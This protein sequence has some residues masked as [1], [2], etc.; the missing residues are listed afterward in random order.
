MIAARTVPL[1]LCALLAHASPLR[2]QDDAG[3]ELFDAEL[4]AEAE[5]DSDGGAAMDMEL[6][7][8]EDGDPVGDAAGDE[9]EDGADPGTAPVPEEASTG[10]PGRALRLRAAAGLGFGTLSYERP[11]G[12]GVD[13]LAETPFGAAEALVG[14]HIWP[15]AGLSLDVQ[16]AYQSSFGMSLR[17]DP[18]F[19]LPQR[20]DARYQRGSFSVAPVWRLT[21]GPEPWLLAFPVGVSAQAFTPIEHQFSV[22]RYALGGPSARAELRAPLGKLVSLRV[23]PELQWIVLMNSGLAN[24]G[25]CCQGFAVGAEG[26]IEATVGE[27]FRATL[28]YREAHAFAPA[29]AW[30]FKSVER[31]LTARITGEL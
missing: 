2:A 14:V 28:A 11:E 19:A 29:G 7:G 23:G 13:A 6:E 20:I 15:D 16:L 5:L 27:L 8:D 3:D 24:A 9:V 21:D 18:L 30:R 31:F 17:V 10:Q 22:G 26:A 12:S 1:A 25:A 4:D